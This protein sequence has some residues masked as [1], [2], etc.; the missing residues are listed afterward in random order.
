MWIPAV[1]F[2]LPSSIKS[3][4]TLLQGVCASNAVL[5]VTVTACFPA[6]RDTASNK[7]CKSI[8][9]TGTDY[10]EKIYFPEQRSFLYTVNSLTEQN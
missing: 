8:N 1:E 4:H 10:T 9:C 2:S 5:V 7:W 6:Y 3:S